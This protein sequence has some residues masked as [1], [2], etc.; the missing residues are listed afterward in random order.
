M[1]SFALVHTTCYEMA[2]E[3]QFRILQELLQVSEEKIYLGMK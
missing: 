2:K 3:K 1:L